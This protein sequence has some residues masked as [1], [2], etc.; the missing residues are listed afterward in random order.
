MDRKIQQIDSQLERLEGTCNAFRDCG[1]NSGDEVLWRDLSRQAE[2]CT[3]MVV[4]LLAQSAIQRD[5]ER[6]HSLMDRLDRFERLI[7]FIRAAL[8]RSA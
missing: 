2:D 6:S 3:K 1:A 8:Q 4:R 7:E 5:E